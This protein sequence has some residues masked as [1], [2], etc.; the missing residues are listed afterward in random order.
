MKVG[1]IRIIIAA[2]ALAVDTGRNNLA[3][4]AQACRTLV[5]SKI[6]DA[7][8]TLAETVLPGAFRPPAALPPSGPV[9]GLILGSE[10]DLPEFCRIAAVSKPTQDS[11][12]KFEV[13]MPANWNGKFMGVG[14]GGMG[15]SISY[16]LLSGVL[17]RGYATASTNTGHQGRI[18]DGSYALGHR[19]KVV[20]FGY[21]AVHEMTVVAKELIAAYYGRTAKFSYWNGCSTGG[22]QA[23]TEAQ[24]FPADYDG[25]IAGAP[26]N[27]L[28]HLQ[29]SS[30]WKAQA[31]H[32][33]PG[34]LIP[35]SK[36]LLLHDS[37]VEACDTRDG[38]KDR[39]IEDPRG[40]DFHPKAIECKGEDRPDCLTAAQ[41]AVA[42]A[43]YSP[44]VN[45]R[46][47]EE[48]YPGLMRGSEV[49]WSSDMGRMH[50]D[51]T[52]TLASEYLRYAIF[53]NPEWDYTSF[54]YDSDMAFAERVDEGV[55]KAM[56]PDLR[57]FFR[58][59]GRLLQYHGWSDPSISP[60]NS[61]NYYN[62]VLA[63]MRG[64]ARVPES[65]RLYMVPGMDHCGGGDG[66]NAFDAI[67]TIEQWVEV[68][69]APDRIIATHV[70]GGQTERTPVASLTIGGRVDRTRPLCPYPQV[71]EYTGRGSTDDASNF[72]CKAP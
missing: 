51:V 70:S 7:T 14:N 36:L 53:Q 46:T 38:L 41:V 44:T 49:G 15:G 24:R 20:D 40:C 30:I 26:A 37:A 8:I 57:E 64:A 47:R 68:G 27:S 50:A 21:R 72:R 29:A 32:N 56:N 39:L 22:R 2:A 13:W 55:T 54:N 23:L 67:G 63:F 16:P 66:P 69:K 71:A 33:N 59:G 31:I 35:P 58:R 12:I 10:I 34:G 19:E 18:N 25:I 17:A 48:I 28:T 5:G 45:P 43:F 9:G 65:Y 60:L 42:E 62:S 11:E 6:P 52:S 4:A 1:R 61:I 3:T